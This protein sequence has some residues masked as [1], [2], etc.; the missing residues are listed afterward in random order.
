MVLRPF[1][2]EFEGSFPREGL[3]IG[4]TTYSG[5]TLL[6]KK[7]W[8]K[9]SD[10][11]PS[12]TETLIPGPGG[13]SPDR[14]L[15]RIMES[16]K[17][18][19]TLDNEEVRGV[20]TKHYRAHLDNKKPGNLHAGGKELVV[21]AWV[22]GEGLLRRLR[23]PMGPAG[24]FTLDFFDYGVDVDLK[25]PSDGELVTQS[26]LYDLIAAECKQRKERGEPWDESECTR[27]DVVEG[28]SEELPMKTVT[29]P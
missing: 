22:D 2:S 16:S 18:V 25:P 26:E 28:E 29:S 12:G 5:W 15:A 1:G 3:F 13:P 20:E 9:E 17:R 6:G 24:E 19:E 21:D 27:E 4:K 10:Y 7:R 8:L 11:T 14:V 23:I